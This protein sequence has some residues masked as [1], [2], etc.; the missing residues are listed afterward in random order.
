MPKCDAH[1]DKVYQESGNGEEG[2]AGNKKRRVVQKTQGH[3]AGQD[4]FT[5]QTLYGGA[6]FDRPEIQSVWTEN[7]CMI[8]DVDHLT[9]PMCDVAFICEFLKNNGLQ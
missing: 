2:E 1:R 7:R 4:F 8:I 3:G 9:A 5:M 6:G